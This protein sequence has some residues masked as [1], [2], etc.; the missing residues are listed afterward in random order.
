MARSSFYY[1]LH[2]AA[3]PER[4]LRR[5]GPQT[6]WSDAALLGKIR[7]VLAASPFYGEGHRKVWARLRFRT[8]KARC[9][10]ADERRSC[11][12]RRARSR[13]QRILTTA[14]SSPSGPTKSGPATTP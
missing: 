9:A 12:R 14:R 13:G 1:Q 8:S 4:V 10:A 2:V 11:S 6:A 3:Q 7:E 5:R